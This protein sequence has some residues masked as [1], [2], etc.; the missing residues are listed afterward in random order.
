RRGQRGRHPTGPVR[1]GGPGRGAGTGAVLLE[2]EQEGLAGD[3]G[4][5]GERAVRRKGD[6]VQRVGGDV[7][8]GLRRTGGGDGVDVLLDQRVRSGR[9]AVEFGDGRVREGAG[10]V[11]AGR[12]ARRAR[13]GQPRV[14]ALR[15]GARGGAVGHRKGPVRGQVAAAG[16]P[17]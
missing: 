16:E 7:R 12:A 2:R 9:D 6:V 11:A 15:G 10:Q 17:G 3:R 4:R 13:V 1:G 8:D 14:V 5:E